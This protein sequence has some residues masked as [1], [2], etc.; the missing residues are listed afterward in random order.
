MIAMPGPFE[1]VA[2]LEIAYRGYPIASSDCFWHPGCML[3]QIRRR[4]KLWSAVGV[5]VVLLA[6]C[7]GKYWPTQDGPT[8]TRVGDDLCDSLPFEVF[9]PALGPVLA[10][11]EPG[12]PQRGKGGGC[13]VQFDTMVDIT[14]TAMVVLFDSSGEAEEDYYAYRPG[15]ASMD[16]WDLAVP[17]KKA[18]WWLGRFE[19]R[20]MALDGNMVV[21]VSV[22]LG[23]TFDTIDVHF[24]DLMARFLS[25]AVDAV[26]KTN[27]VSV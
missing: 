5:V 27:H 22:Q 20:G 12:I 3:G 24:G 9:E 14:M 19:A 4:W 25:A 2:G 21:L 7:V 8:Y 10:G 26:R 17:V 13:Q 11:P 6:V 15:A 23:D 18:Q 1:H 16:V